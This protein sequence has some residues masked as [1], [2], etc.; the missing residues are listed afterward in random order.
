MPCGH[1]QRHWGLCLQRLPGHAAAETELHPSRKARD[2]AQ[3]AW[4]SIMPSCTIDLLSPS[5]CVSFGFVLSSCVR[6]SLRRSVCAIVSRQVDLQN[7]NRKVIILRIFRT[8]LAARMSVN[9]RM[10]KQRTDQRQNL[11]KLTIPRPKAGT[12][13]LSPDQA[14][15]TCARG[16]RTFALRV[17]TGF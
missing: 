6:R 2:E 16:V 17:C 3:L 7:S 4:T 9:I 15:E 14:C 11:Y 10:T 13:I 1:L 12:F 8:W 5:L